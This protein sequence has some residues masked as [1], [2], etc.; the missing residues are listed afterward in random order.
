MAVLHM[1]EREYL[2]MPFGRL[3]DLH[4]CHL[5]TLEQLSGGSD[6]AP[7]GIDEIIPDGI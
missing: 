6:G 5:Q 3:I 7:A 1:S 4:E 2:L